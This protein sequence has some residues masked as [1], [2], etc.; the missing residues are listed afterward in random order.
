MRLAHGETGTMAVYGRSSLRIFDSISY[1]PYSDEK[2]DLKR[3]V[4]RTR[5]VSGVGILILCARVPSRRS[6]DC[7]A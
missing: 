3:R 6:L 7:V 2:H 4:F 1:T 5:P